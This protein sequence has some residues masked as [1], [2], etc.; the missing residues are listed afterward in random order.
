MSNAVANVREDEVL[1][2]LRIML[3]DLVLFHSLKA[4]AKT[5]FNAKDLRE[6]AVSMTNSC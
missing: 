3:E 4:D 2:E 6:A 5:N 1:V